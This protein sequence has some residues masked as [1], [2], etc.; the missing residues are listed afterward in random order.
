MAGRGPLPGRNTPSRA[1]SR[2]GGD[3][4]ARHAAA[5]VALDANGGYDTHE[6]QETRCRPPRAA[7]ASL[8]AFQA[9]LEA[10][11]VA[12]RVLVTSGASSAAGRRPTARE[13]TTAP[14]A[15]AS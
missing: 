5:R 3:D 15:R 2:A 7:A 13:P 8:A 11:G 14:A 9:D 1:G 4:L 12:D 10:R 6:N